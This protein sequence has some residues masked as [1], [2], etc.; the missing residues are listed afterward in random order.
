M[1]DI[2]LLLVSHIGPSYPATHVQLWL[3]SPT[4]LQ[5]APFKHGV[6]RQEFKSVIND[7]LKL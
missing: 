6:E 4:L 5:V 3:L 1:Y 2:W 7:E